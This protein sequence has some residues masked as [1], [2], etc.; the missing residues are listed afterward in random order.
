MLPGAMT[1][2][3][4]WYRAALRY[5]PLLPQNPYIS[6]PTLIL[7]GCQDRFLGSELAEMSVLYCTRCRLVLFE[8]G[9]HWLHHE[10]PQRVNQLIQAFIE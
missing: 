6:T 7:W 3:L 1:A 8:R 4:N 10:E 2:M 5:R 9:T